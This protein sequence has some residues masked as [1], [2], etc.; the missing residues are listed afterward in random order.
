MNSPSTSHLLLFR[1]ETR[2]SFLFAL[3]GVVCFSLQEPVAAVGQVPDLRIRMAWEKGRTTLPNYREVE[4]RYRLQLHPRSVVEVRI[5][6]RKQVIPMTGRTGRRGET[7]GFVRM[8]L[9]W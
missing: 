8:T 6:G 1:R 2:V 9:S 4:A 5:R 3:V 7:N